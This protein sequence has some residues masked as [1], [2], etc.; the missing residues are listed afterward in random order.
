MLKQPSTLILAGIAF[1]LTAAVGL[2]VTIGVVSGDFR[3]EPG[4]IELDVTDALRRDHLSHQV[5][6]KPGEDRRS[7]ALVIRV[8]ARRFDEL[9]MIAPAERSIESLQLCVDPPKPVDREDPV[10]VGR[11]NQ[12]RSR[13][14]QAPDV[15]QV[16][17]CRVDPPHAITVAVDHAVVNMRL[18]R[19]SAARGRTGGHTFVGRCNPPG[20]RSATR[21]ASHAEPPGVHFGARGEQVQAAGSAVAFVAAQRLE[22]ALNLAWRELLGPMP[23]G[24]MLAFSPHT[25]MVSH[26]VGTTVVVCLLGA[27]IDRVLSQGSAS[28]HRSRLHPEN[29]ITWRPPGKPHLD[30]VDVRG[31]DDDR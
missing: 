8:S 12:Q 2:V 15:G 18:N 5:F 22:Y 16:P 3:L 10:L 28:R 1:A 17:A 23:L 26:A 6:D 14:D 24:T 4:L 30:H 11:C 9:Q 27:A 13:G 31:H 29:E 20:G 7:R 19:S 25:A 21:D